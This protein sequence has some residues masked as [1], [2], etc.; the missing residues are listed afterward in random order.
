MTHYYKDETISA[1]RL[2]VQ[3]KRSMAFR[4][5]AYVYLSFS[6]MGILSRFQSHPFLITWWDN[7]S[8]ARELSFLIQPQS[9]IAVELIPRNAIRSVV[10][11]GLYGKDL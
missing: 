10:I 2:D 11:D 7:S 9:G 5:G 1:I 3:L 6:G 8:A 4:P